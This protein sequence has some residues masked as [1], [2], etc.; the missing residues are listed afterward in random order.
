M[1]WL[2]ACPVGLLCLP[3]INSSKRE[4]WEAALAQPEP[5]V[6]GSSL[7]ATGLG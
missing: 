6:R 1:L 7:H 4:W 2:S 5:W 3:A